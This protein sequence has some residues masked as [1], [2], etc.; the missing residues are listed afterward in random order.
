[1]NNLW[2]EVGNACLEKAKDLLQSSER[3]S[4]ARILIDAAVSLEMVNLRWAELDK[5]RSKA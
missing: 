5:R 3:V 1:M 2:I 4:E